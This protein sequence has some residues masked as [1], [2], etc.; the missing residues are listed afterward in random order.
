MAAC[1]NCGKDNEPGARF[2]S[3]CGAALT[4][5]APDVRK[6]V[7]VLFCDVTGSTA[8]GE[9]LDPEAARKLMSRY[10]ET[11][12]GVLERHGASVEKFIGDAVMA[13]FGIPHVHEDDALRAAR[14]ALELRD[15][16]EE[17]EVRIGVNTGEVVTGSG[18]TL[19]TGDA[20]NVA[21]RLEQSAAPGAIL[22]GDQTF[23]LV[24]D[25]V[26]AEEVEPIEAKGKSRP[27]RA[28]RLMRVREDAAP[29]TRR[30][31]SP[32]V[33]RERE[34]AQLDESFTRAE[35]ERVCHLATVLGPPGI[36]KSRRAQETVSRLGE[37]ALV[38][39]GRCLSYGDGITYWPLLEILRDLGEPA[40]IV[41]LL[42]GEADAR[43]I[44]N[45]VFAAVGLAEGAA[46]PEETSRAVRKL[47]EGLAR[48][49]PLVVVLDDLH[50]AEPTFLDLVDHVADLSRDAPL[51]LLCLARGDLLDTRPGWAAGKHNATTL[52]LDPLSADEAGALIAMLA[53]TEL[54][55]NIRARI[56][57]AADGNPLFVEQMLA[58]LGED[59]ANG[60]VQVPPTIQALLAARLDRLAPAERALLGRASVVG[61]EFW[62]RALDALGA[63]AAPLPALVR[64]ELIQPYRSTVF[65]EDD[66]YRFRHDLIRDAAYGAIPK[67]T[68]AQLHNGFA[69]W[70][71][72]QRSELDEIVGYHLEQ[73]YR[74]RAEL[75][76]ASPEL[77]ERAGR[78][79]G[80]GGL[81]AADRADFPAAINLLTRAVAL[82]PAKDEGRLDL[83]EHLAYAHYDAGTLDAAD[84][85]FGEALE[86]AGERTVLRSRATV[87]RLAVGHMLGGKMAQSFAGIE[88]ELPTLEAAGDSTALAEAYREAA[89]IMSHGGRSELADTL[90]EKAVENAKASGNRR[91]EADILMW[92]MAMQCW[93]YLPASEGIR[94]ANGV[95]EQRVGG[96][97]EAFALVVR[98]RYRALQG[99]LAGGRADMEA[100]RAL[101]REYGAAFYI[102][103]SGQE[104]GQMELES[105]DPAVAEKVL[106]ETYEMYNEMG[107]G[108]LSAAAASLLARAF[109]G[110]GDLDKAERFASICE[111]TAPADDVFAQIEYRAVRARVLA[112]RGEL[113]TAEALAHKSVE[114]AEQ[115]DYFEHHAAARLALGEALVR[116]GRSD[117][118]RTEFERAIE[119]SERQE[120][121][122]G[123]ERA[124]ARLR[125][126]ERESLA[127][128]D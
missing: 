34:L 5:L 107:G 102:A 127:E 30:L 90:F 108:A 89:K 40:D 62:L 28:Y 83:L 18:E 49:Q 22:L 80:S 70:I 4:A 66:A 110:Q 10:F 125:E 118:A 73:A 123:I 43:R 9:R 42:E 11:A 94:V 120:S 45:D 3:A 91:I 13:V 20:V 44:V 19:V 53:E 126:L 51:L 95:L 101:I 103:G 33:G 58:M 106:R 78:L 32:L 38:V 54:D 14:A 47:F 76:D 88:H 56:S 75:G 92:R 48:E 21:A 86:H 112:Q 98:G 37:R 124:R 79:L 29:F 109:L 69:D 64:K 1:P 55:E 105:G 117:E 6:T 31:D 52:L 15:S 60:E 41:A 67:E 77:A 17:L 61:K 93:G 57:S 81:R 8:L 99:D 26:E 72:Q 25:A 27:L 96:M 119:L 122:V 121:V 104:N 84:A 59:G 113:D 115:T 82:M 100:G 71:A 87:G 85:L 65:P 46:R 68:R 111:T 97:A 23:E 116:A 39:R 128:R 2:C 63:D 7:T 16:V 12:R 50:W 74:F 36:G 35:R 24:R 114:L